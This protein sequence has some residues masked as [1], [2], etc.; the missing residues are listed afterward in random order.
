[1]KCFLASVLIAALGV[2]TIGCENKKGTEENKTQTTT[3]Q[4]KDG[5]VTGETTNTVD[6]KTTTTP[7]TPGSGGT[8]TEK[9]HQD[10]QRDDQVIRCTGRLAIDGP[11][12]VLHAEQR[13][14]E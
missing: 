3:T 6:T 13:N 10:D 12:K 5:K 7:A 2:V 1:M 4:T 9:T 11:G 14:L 8:T